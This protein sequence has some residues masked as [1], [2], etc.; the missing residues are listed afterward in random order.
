V[1]R[2]VPAQ[3]DVDAA[4]LYERA[5]ALHDLGEHT[6]AEHLWRQAADAGH[7]GA[8]RTLEE[9][10]NHRPQEPGVY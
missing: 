3:H 8:Q 1:T 4:A 6:A 2:V 5:V 9:L 10:A 7:A